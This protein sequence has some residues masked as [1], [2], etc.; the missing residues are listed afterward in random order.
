MKIHTLH[1]L[2]SKTGITLIELLIVV[3]IVGI[4]AAIAV[5]MYTSYMQR[6]RRVD[7]KTALEQVRASQEM[8]RA[9]RGGYATG[10]GAIVELRN[11]WGGPGTTSGDYN[12]TLVAT[13]ATFTGTATP[14]T[15]RQTPDGA[16]TI[17]QDGLKLPAA[18]WSK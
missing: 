14:N 13:T 16:L 17:N 2:K 1:T 7:A 18:K 8:R 9:E 6:A 15:S 10:V 12:I 5:P 3:V 4:L 11:T